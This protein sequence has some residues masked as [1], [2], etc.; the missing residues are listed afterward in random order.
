MRK[1]LGL[2]PL[3]LV[4]CGS[5]ERVGAMAPRDQMPAPYYPGI[6]TATAP[7]EPRGTES[8]EGYG[9][10]PSVDPNKDRLSTFAV[11]VDTASYTI[12]RRKLMNENV[13]P[14]YAAVRAEEYLNFFRYSYPAPA[15]GRF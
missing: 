9:I 3:F 13:L 10:N 14:P 8:Y 4:A 7:A 11:D 5:A 2:L 12:S 15:Q 1:I 6:G